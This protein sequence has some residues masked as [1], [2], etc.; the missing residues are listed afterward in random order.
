MLN[1]H[2]PAVSVCGRGRPRTQ[3]A[4]GSLMLP[5]CC[6]LHSAVRTPEPR[7]GFHA[8]REGFSPHAQRRARAGGLRLA[9]PRASARRLA[10]DS[11][12]IAQSPSARRLARNTGFISQSSSAPRQGRIPDLFLNLHQPRGKGR[13]PVYSSSHKDWS[14]WTELNTPSKADALCNISPR[15]PRLCVHHTGSRGGVEARR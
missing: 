12:F 4:R 7:R 6:P 1:L 5:T 2:Q 8:L 9:C 15:A 14:C 10:R 11:G 13:I 3:D